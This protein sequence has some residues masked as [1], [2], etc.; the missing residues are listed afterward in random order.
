MDSLCDAV[1]FGVA[2]AFLM[3]QFTRADHSFGAQIS[4]PFQYHPRLLWVIA[5]LFV[6][7]VLLRLARF[8]VETDEDDTHEDFSGLPSPA[9]A[10]TVAAFPI[11]MHGL[12]D[13][14][15]D[16]SAVGDPQMSAHAISLWLIPFAV[17]ALPLVT[18]A[19]ASLMV[20]RIRYA[21][22]F[23]Q[24]FKGQ[25]SRQHVLQLV[26]TL[27]LI[28]TVKELAVPVIFCYFAFAAPLRAAWHE[29]TKRWMY[30][31]KI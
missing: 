27:A 15:F 16:G 2:P 24:L 23:N 21:H 4:L 17:T 29:L 14:V 31:S 7:C 12:V 11:A 6:V 8:N 28:F 25:R 19:V 30:R 13:T 20:S 22:V 26:F 1:S 3:L 5:V 18:L 9:A 10:G